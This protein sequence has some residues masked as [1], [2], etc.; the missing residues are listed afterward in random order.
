MIS[1]IIILHNE[2]LYVRY[3]NISLPIFSLPFNQSDKNQTKLY[4]NQAKKPRDVDFIGFS[5]NVLFYLCK[6]YLKS[7]LVARNLIKSTFKG[8]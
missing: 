2:H 6:E 1:Y 3:Y 7:I 8:C 5:F 4:F